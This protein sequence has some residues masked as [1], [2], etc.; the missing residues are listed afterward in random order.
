MGKTGDSSHLESIVVMSGFPSQTVKHSRIRIHQ[1]Y[2]SIVQPWAKAN[3]HLVQAL[4]ID[5]GWD[6]TQDGDV[7]MTHWTH[8]TYNILN[9]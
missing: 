7:E 9:Y 4:E 5:L 6:M 8:W 3:R 1:S 2:I